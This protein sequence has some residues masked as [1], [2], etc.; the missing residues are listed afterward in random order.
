MSGGQKRN[1]MRFAR[2]L[3]ACVAFFVA[4]PPV[5]ATVWTDHVV[6]V[7]SAEARTSTTEQKDATEAS[8]ASIAGPHRSA[9]AC[10]LPLSFTAEHA[11]SAPVIVSRRYLRNCSFLC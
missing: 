6:L 5:Q 8:R 2:L 3:I 9:S 4:R 10:C 7:A 1:W 11:I